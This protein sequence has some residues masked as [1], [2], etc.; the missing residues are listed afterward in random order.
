MIKGEE[1]DWL[2]WQEAFSITIEK[3]E[4]QVSGRD[5]VRKERGTR[6]KFGHG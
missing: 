6:W 3:W 4:K 1:E 2:V 5:E